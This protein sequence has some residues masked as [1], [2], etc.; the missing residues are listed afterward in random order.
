MT[1]NIMTNG[2]AINGT[3]GTSTMA[4]VQV[5]SVVAAHD[6]CGHV[7]TECKRRNKKRD[8]KLD[9]ESGKWLDDSSSSQLSVQPL[10]SQRLSLPGLCVSEDARFAGDLP[11]AAWAS[12]AMY[13][14]ESYGSVSI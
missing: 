9:R 13:R 10:S 2:I 5:N 6:V 11:A 7:R 14:N 1:R 3:T 12:F 4:G 8:L